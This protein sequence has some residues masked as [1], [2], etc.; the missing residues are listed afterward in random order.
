[1][2]KEPLIVI[3]GVATRD[4]D[5]FGK[6][7]AALEKS[8]E[9]PHRLIP[10]FWGDLARPAEAVDD[11]LPYL[12]WLSE[13]KLQF[14][15]AAGENHAQDFL[16][17]LGNALAR[18]DL[19]SVSSMLSEGWRRYGGLSRHAM[20]GAVYSLF[21]EHY[22]AASAE[23]M[24]DVLFYQSRQQEIQA[25]I[26]ESIMREAPGY[27]LPEKPIGAIAHS[28]GGVMLFDLAVSGHPALHLK[29][30]FTCGSQIPFFHVIGCSPPEIGPYVRGC[31]T[32]LSANIGKWT[33]FYVPLDLWAFLA[34]PVF[35]LHDGDPPKDI[36]VYGGDKEDRFFRHAAE[37]Y[38]NHPVVIEEIR[39]GLDGNSLG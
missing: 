20:V 37:H 5:L 18:R 39:K 22:L 24:G 17:N 11:V 30:L 12:G 1:M 3:H 10:V 2:C 26:W 35:Q 33:N 38:W 7:V 28:L 32:L 23:F 9:S 4:R 21:R 36:E 19:E 31:K 34:E 27:G 13:P 14:A 25:R 29:H 16:G 15:R 6:E 8:L